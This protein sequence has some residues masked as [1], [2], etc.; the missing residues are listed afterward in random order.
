MNLPG[1]VQTVPRSEYYAFYYLIINAAQ[2]SVIHFVTDHQP[3]FNTFQ[4]GISGARKC[5]NKDILVEAFEVIDRKRLTVTMQWMPS[6]LSPESTELP[7][8]TS[9]HDVIA[10]GFADRYA[11]E[12]ADRF[13]IDLGIASTVLCDA[14]LVK[15][16][17][18]R[19]ATIICHLPN[20]K[21]EPNPNPSRRI[22]FNI[23]EAMSLSTH[24]CIDQGQR[25]L[26]ARCNSNCSKSHIAELKHWL[27]RPCTKVGS[28]CDR[29]VR[30]SIDT[31]SMHIGRQSIHYTHTLHTFNGLMCCNSCGFYTQGIH[32]RNLAKK[33]ELP[34]R[35]GQR[36][37]K[38]LRDARLPPNL[39]AWP[40]NVKSGPT[41]EQIALNNIRDQ[42]NA[43]QEPHGHWLSTQP[44]EPDSD[45]EI[46]YDVADET[47]THPAPPN[48]VL[49]AC[50]SLD[51]PFL[52]LSESSIE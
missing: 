35:H 44:P 31:A 49:Q 8:G 14:S 46:T 9:M 24:L 21:R 45:V 22:K 27:Q 25:V 23:D 3:L 43:V 34:T 13:N 7:A 47:E 42:M 12:A 40:A 32:M 20:R 30:L 19:L 39:H 6:H 26:C 33:C 37:L 16:I 2:E 5:I 18:L 51:D 15:R 48:G 28:P 10:N 29:P 52:C 36:S 41:F 11:K 38:A 1:S 17:Q 50:S 4:K